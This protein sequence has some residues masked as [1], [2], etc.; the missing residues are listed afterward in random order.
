VRPCDYYGKGRLNGE[1]EIIPVHV[2][3]EYAQ[4]WYE[5]PLEIRDYRAINAVPKSIFVE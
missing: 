1:K 3:P 2:Q 5:V 4:G